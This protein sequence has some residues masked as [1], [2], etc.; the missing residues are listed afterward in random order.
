MSESMVCGIDVGGPRKGY[1]ICVLNGTRVELLAHATEP[2]E[3]IR[4]LQIHTAHRGQ[5]IQAIAVDG[6]ARAQRATA[7]IRATEAE[8]AR[9]GYRV[10]YTPEERPEP[11]H[12]MS[13]SE[14]IHRECRKAFRDATMLE[15]Y[16]TAVS[17]RLFGLDAEFPLSLLQEKSK[18]KQVADYLD[19]YLCALAAQR[20]I[21]GEAEIL[22][23]SG[24]D[25]KSQCKLVLPQFTITRATLSF[26]IRGNNVLLGMKK[27][28]FGAGY[29]N[30]F[31]GKIEPG[32]TP[33]QAAVR[34]IQEECGLHALELSPAGK[35]YFHF[36]DDPRRIEGYLF[37]TSRFTGDP[38]ETAEMRP[39]WF[40]IKDLPFE[41]MW[42]DDRF[43][44]PY[45]LQG[46]T[47][48]GTFRFKARKM[49]DY[50][51]D[52]VD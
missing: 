45:V 15:T 29:W 43:W 3:L 20:F 10:L 8:L 46:K 50:S 49:Q 23:D 19:A 24:R 27:K 17:D 9:R 32:E 35:L 2:R 25:N 21:C 52:I 31:G 44:L 51:L 28:G 42:E 1:H 33:K 39:S 5:Y 48:H 34:E 37:R 13:R 26:L 38:V 41:Q 12:W 36:D 16:P 18:R 47:I 40:S 4:L 30:G 6:P 22:E 14:A 11:D 7:T